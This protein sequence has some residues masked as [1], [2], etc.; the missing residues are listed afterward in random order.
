M[1]YDYLI[2]GIKLRIRSLIPLREGERWKSFASSFAE[3]DHEYILHFV[4]I[5]PPFPAETGIKG[6][7]V[8]C[9][10]ADNRPFRTYLKSN[11]SAYAA[12]LERNE[13]CWEVS[14]LRGLLPWGSDVEH[15]LPLLGL[16]RIFLRH[17]RL[18]LHGAY[19]E[20]AYGGV[21]F[22]APSGT[23][24]TTQA[25]LWRRYRDCLIVNGDRAILSCA[26]DSPTIHSFIHSGS[27]PDCLNVKLPLFAVVE[28]S[29]G[30]EN[31]LLRLDGRDAI[32]ALMRSAYL[33]PEFREDL[34]SLILQ[35]EILCRKVPLIHLSCLPDESAVEILDRMFHDI[36]NKPQKNSAQGTSVR[37]VEEE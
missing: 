31:R 35:T 8:R 18:L 12:V 27:S 2:G 9:G 7:F 13:R 1:H 10:L 19:I 21:L 30:K 37:R 17:S 5:L 26:E 22:I 34:L 20:T 6:E 11:G 3:P 25:E 15:L 23:G 14:L 24:K 32:R 36:M 33:L 4:D 28:L 16:P 29:Q